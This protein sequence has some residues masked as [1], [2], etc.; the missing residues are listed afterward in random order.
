MWKIRVK[1]TIIFCKYVVVI[2]P[3]II[4]DSLHASTYN[5]D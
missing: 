4:L 3:G 5:Y 2:M 1:I